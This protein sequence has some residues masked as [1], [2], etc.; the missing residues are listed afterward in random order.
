EPEVENYKLLRANV[1]INDLEAKVVTFNMAVSNRVGTA[2]LKLRPEFGAKH[3]LVEGDEPGA[4][5]VTVPLTTLDALAQEGAFQPERAGRVW[6][7]VE[8]Q[9]L[10]ALQ[11]A[12]TLVERAVPIVIEFIPRALKREG[13]LEPLAALLARHYTH[14]V[15]LREDG[16]PEP[17]PV[18]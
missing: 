10:E 14:V 4:T 18:G 12:T 3:R 7:D 16:D 13:K 17:V 11:G 9:E 2:E 6:L 8:R 5:T 1:A 15:D